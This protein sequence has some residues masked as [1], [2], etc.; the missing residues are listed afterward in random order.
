M[1]AVIP[2]AGVG[3]KLR[4]HTHTQPKPLIPVAGKPILGHIIDNLI[5]A[6][7]RK[8]VF[9]I[10]YLR[11]KVQA[12]VE[13]NYADK[14]EMEFVVQEP[15]K[16][17][18]HALWMSRDLLA[19][20]KEILIVL[21]D[22]IFG[23]DTETILSMEGSVLAV[24][25]VDRPGEFGVAVLDQGGHVRKLTE[26]PNIPTS[27]LAL[28]GM[29]KLTEIKTLLE[30]L[31]KRVS[32]GIREEEDYPL[33]EALQSMVE[34]GFKMRTLA[35]HDWFDCGRSETLLLANRILLER[36][37]GAKEYN[38]PNTVIIPPVWISEGCVIENS[39]VGP[40]VAIAEHTHLHNAIVSDS[41][42]GA[43]ARLE[44]ITLNKSV[45]GNDT[46]L[47]GKA[48]SIN[49]GD[50]TEIDFSD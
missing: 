37:D 22:T 30:I 18:G 25:E 40:Y 45:I 24:Q 33:T 23:R 19:D 50:N 34:R 49:I 11:E 39:I 47:R 13:E 20:E 46:L 5:K 28:V 6:G 10:G 48:N 44:S 31:H 41:I 42:L 32:Q 14:I 21:G 43:Y 2:V 8:Q 26:K 27:N 16:G 3:T 29:Y 9:I 36:E 7:V 12:Y 4:P 17:L 1:K 35:V 38:F 15:R